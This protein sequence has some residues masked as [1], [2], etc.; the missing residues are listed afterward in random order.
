LPKVVVVVE[1]TKLAA[2]VAQEV[3]AVIMEHRRLLAVQAHK[4]LAE[5]HH[6]A[7]LLTVMRVPRAAPD[8]HLAVRVVVVQLH[9]VVLTLVLLV[10]TV[11]LVCR[12]VLLE[13]LH[14]MQAVV[15]AVALIIRHPWV[16]QVEQVVVVMAVVIPPMQLRVLPTPAVAVEAHPIL[17]LALPAEAVLLLY[18][19]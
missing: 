3:V 11:A 14:T 1:V 2:M 16:V 13:H 12:I 15:Q 18:D 6:R 10:A 17:E 4:R 7:E 19:I 5:Q 8:S 9:Q